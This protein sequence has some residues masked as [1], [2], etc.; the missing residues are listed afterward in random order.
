M[1]SDDLRKR[2]NW[3]TRSGAAAFDL[4]N[5]FQSIFES[6]F[7]KNKNT[8][9]RIRKNPKEFSRIYEH[10]ALD[11]QTKQAIYQPDRPYRHG[12]A[13][14]FAIDNVSDN[15]T[16][17][18]ELKRQDGWIEGLHQSAGRGN[19]HERLCKFFTPGLLNSL[20]ECGGISELSLPFWVVFG[21]NITRDPKRVRE[22]TLWFG[23]YQH[24]FFMWRD[25]PD[26]K[27]LINHFNTYLKPLLSPH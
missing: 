18:I 9:F 20:R 16:L 25:F 17:Y 8:A 1:G 22:I 10:V 27:S 23:E 2:D 6:E 13:I 19:A 14:D 26:G 15:K 11:K 21:G 24:H 12:I 7:Q 5:V 4:E 3:Q